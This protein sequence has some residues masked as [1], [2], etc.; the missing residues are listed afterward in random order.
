[1]GNIKQEIEDKTIQIKQLMLQ[2]ENQIHTTFKVLE[3]AVSDRSKA[4]VKHTSKWQH[5]SDNLNVEKK[6]QQEIEK[7]HQDTQ[8]SIKANEK[9]KEGQQKELNRMEEEHNKLQS[10]YDNLQG[11]L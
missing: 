11:E 9:K 2:K 8:N 3:S 10:K 7:N 4:L 6:H 5:A 1:M